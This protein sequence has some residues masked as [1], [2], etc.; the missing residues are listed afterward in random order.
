MERVTY[1]SAGAGSG[2]TYTL[3]H[4]LAEHIAGMRKKENGEWE[5]CGQVEPEKVIL[6]TYTKKAAAE[7]REK[8]KSVLYEEGRNNPML[9]EA[10]ARLE[11]ASIGT[12]HAVANS[13]VQ[14]Y[15]YYLG[16]S[17][18]QKVIAEEDVNF[19][20]SQSLAELPTDDEIKFL[21]HFRY[22][23]N[24]EK[25]RD[26]GNPAM[27][28][29]PDYGYW[30]D[31]LVQVIKKS[32]TFS[33][34][35]LTESRQKSLDLVGS[36][37][38]GNLAMPTAEEIV[39]VIK[40]LLDAISKATFKKEDTRI[41]VAES[42]K[43]YESVPQNLSFLWIKDFKE[44]LSDVV[45]R[46]TVAK[47][48]PKAVALNGKVNIWNCP[49]VRTMNEQLVN[50]IFDMAERWKEGY[51]KY[52]SQNHLLDYDD[53]ERYM[54]ELLKRDDVREDIRSSYEYLFVD[55]FQDS[56]PIQ[57][58]IFDE[59]SKLMKQSYWVG[60]YKQAIY[61]FRGTDTELVKAVVDSINKGQDGNHL[62]PPLD[63]CWRS[64]PT[65]TNMVNHVFIPVFGKDNLEEKMVRLEP[66]TKKADDPVVNEPLLLWNL[67]Y[68]KKEE[69]IQE[70]AR[71]I[72]VMVLQG[73]KPSDIAVL[74]NSN[75]DLNTLA[76]LLRKYNL[77]VHRSDGSITEEKEKQL[78]FALLSLLVNKR[79]SMAML[80]IHYLT[81]PDTSLGGLIDQKLEDP[82]FLSNHPL[83]QQLFSPRNKF[84]QQSVSSL[85]ES[86][87]IEMDLYGESRH[88]DTTT[89][90]FNV[91]RTCIEIARQY[92]EHC[93]Q[94]GLPATIS[95]YMNYVDTTEVKT[96]GDSDGVC[97]YTIHGSKGLEW[98]YVI[99]TSL[100]NDFKTKFYARNFF[101][102]QTRH[103]TTPSADNLYIPMTI[104]VLPWI[105]GALQN[106]P[107][108]IMASI[109]GEDGENEITLTNSVK[110]EAK[111]KLY[112]GMTRAS[113]HLILAHIKTKKIGDPMK[114]FHNIDVTTEVLTDDMTQID[115]FKSQDIFT[116]E[117]LP[118]PE[119]DKDA[120]IYPSQRNTDKVLSLKVDG[121][122]AYERRDIQPSMIDCVADEV[123]VL[124]DEPRQRIPIENVRDEDTMAKVGTCIHNI[125]CAI[126]VNH[127]EEFVKSAILAHE[128][129]KHLT[130]AQPILQ[131]WDWL[132]DFMTNQF[133][134]AIAIYH[135]RPFK[136]ESNGQITTGS[137][138]LVWKTEKGCI[139][140]D[141]KTYPNWK[142]ET[143]TSPENKHYAGKYKGQLDCYE[144]ALSLS[145]ENV[146]AK[147]IY[148]PVNGMI[149]QI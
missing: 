38:L 13:F 63:T 149:I 41:K 80:Q 71:R 146:I 3:T 127:N 86:V 136:Y 35:D 27:G 20:I 43:K 15:W 144:H 117:C 103:E 119:E 6:T 76:E 78:L 59:L 137:I 128:M 37:Y 66:K 77:P 100:E 96:E 123:N 50:T 110:S 34:K 5:P 40:E 120:L 74:N 87:I 130:N 94:L 122:D 148:Y 31:L 142:K 98:K 32:E 12:V 91:L 57:V 92:E 95:G 8:A 107:A 45:S 33:V 26:P 39:V 17:P 46:K 30:K 105:F 79:N 60:D 47:L 22:Q 113:E 58:Q 132:V 55:E 25:L 90:G 135:E 139:V 112:V 138:D 73:I 134:P 89:R 140:I 19:Y 97:L 104:T 23:F 109:Q 145:G 24:I 53:M 52:K 126:D 16:L 131:A 72:A 9:Y 93:L 129:Q 67:N 28:S 44:A 56:S 70:I 21:N 85:V 49:K 61:G 4:L 75:S 81:T 68:D 69:A 82:D 111:R 64:E 10:A 11:Q 108:E 118:F 88:W 141:Y 147:L 36:L 101:G 114:W 121:A 83:I 7:F 102:V 125:F 106:P 2:K 84:N 133:G 48:A 65:I 54:L 62:A 143:V 99:V 116:I 29:Y 124:L 42:I 1:I 115:L 51:E 14:K 18:Q